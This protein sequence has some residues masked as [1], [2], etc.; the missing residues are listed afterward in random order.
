MSMSH[1]G[2]PG[3]VI[4]FQNKL[5]RIATCVL[6]GGI[7]LSLSGMASAQVALDLSDA[8]LAPGASGSIAAS[9][10]TDGSAVA[11]Q[12]DVLYDPT[13]VSLGT[14]NA[15]PAL[16][17]NHSIASNPISSGRDRIVITTSPVTALGSGVM[18]TINLTALGSAPA[19]SS[20]L[21]FAGVVISDDTA[22]PITP[23]ALTPGVLTITGGVGPVSPNSNP[24]E[25]IPAIPVWG[26]LLLAGLISL[27]GGRARALRLASV[28]ALALLALGSPAQVLAQNLPG[29]A[30]GDGR[31]DIEDVRLIVER[32]LER[33]VL[34]GDG[35]CN[36]DNA[37][38]VLDT[39]CSQLPFVPGETAPIILGPGDRSIPADIAFEMNLFAADPDERSTQAWSLVNG[40]AG[41]TVSGDGVLTWTPP[42]SAA[43]PNA[44]RIRV[45]DD[46]ARSDEADFSINVFVLP[47]APAAN[48]APVLTVPGN[49]SL[50][51]G[52]PIAAQASATDADAGDTLSFSLINGPAGMTINSSDGTLSWTPQANQPGLAD[53]VIQVEDAAGATDFGSFTVE[54][55]PLNAG[56]TAVDDVYIARKG[57]TLIIPA[58]EGVVQNDEDPNDDSL[59]ATRLSDPALGTVDSFSADG[60]FSYTPDGPPGITIGMQEECQITDSP[61]AQAGAGTLAAGDVDNDG[62][63][64]LAALRRKDTTET[65]VVIIDPVDCTVELAPVLGMGIPDFHGLTTLV[66][67]DD[68]PE[69]ELVKAYSAFQ[70]DIVADE[71]GNGSDQR[72]MAVNIDGSPLDAWVTNH[73][74]GGLSAEPSRFEDLFPFDA[75]ANS[76]VAADLD[77]D[78]SVELLLGYNSATDFSDGLPSKLALVAWDGRSG[79]V[80]WEFVGAQVRGSNRGTWPV[81]VDL[82]LDGDTEIIFNHHVLDHEGNLLFDLP[83]APVQGATFDTL[84]SAVAN[85]DNDAFP[86]IIAY[87]EEAITLFSHDGQIQWQRERLNTDFGQFP[88]SG[89]TIAELDG[90]PLPEFATMLDIDPG[91]GVTLFAFDDNGDELWNQAERGFAAGVF[92]ETSTAVAFD[93]DGDGIDELVQQRGNNTVPFFPDGRPVD[94]PPEE[95]IYIFDGPTGD[96]IDFLPYVATTNTQHPLTVAD[97]DED[98]S[99]EIVI[100]PLVSLG[101]WVMQIIG[102]ISDNPWPGT[103]STRFQTAMQPTYRSADGAVPSTIEPHWLQP[104][105]NAWNRV[106]PDRDP[107]EP[108]TDSFTYRVSDGAFD[109]NT[110]TVNIELRPAGTPPFFLSEPLAGIS[111]GIAY[112]YTPLIVDVDPGDEVTLSL[113]SAPAGMT[114]DPATGTLSWYPE[115]A[116]E[117]PVSILA[118]DTL[119][120]SSAQIFTVSVGDPVIVPDVVGSTEGA[121]ESTLVSANLSKGSVFVASSTT[122]PAGQVLSQTPLAGSAADFGSAVALTLS[123]GPAP[124]DRDDDGDGFSE[125]QGDCDDNNNTIFPGAPDASN[126]GIDQDCD[127]LDGNKTLVAIEISPGSKRVLTG[128]PTPLIAT[129]IFDDGTAQN[130]TAIATWTNGPTFSAGSAGAFQASATFRGVTGTA[131]FTVLDRVAEDLAP[132]ARIDSPA[133]GATVT[134][135]TDIEGLVSDANLLRWELAYRYAGEDDFVVF[136]EGG[137]PA[138][139]GPPIGEFDPTTLLNGLYDIRLRA[140]DRGGN[141]SEDSTTVQVEGQMKIGNFT[142]RYVDLELPLNG[143]PITLARTYD[144]R[145][146]RVGDFG[147]GWRLAVNSIEVR[148]NRELGSAWRVFRQGLTFGLVEEDL[149]L[150]AIRLPDGRIE[151][152]EMVVVPNASPIIPFPPLTQS[153]RFRPLPGTLGT[154]EALGENNVSILDAQPG[155]VTL[156]L[157]SDGSIYNPTLFRYTTRTGQ[158]WISIH[159]RV[160][161]GPSCPAARYSPSRQPQ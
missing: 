69:L 67:L 20:N 9:I 83:H 84:T 71:G 94:P 110:A 125:N 120:L 136:D 92:S 12:F 140:Y 11:L 37:I 109:S 62:R 89:I 25:R 117:Y 63:V 91:A 149:H 95:G 152:F 41:L 135:P 47:A 38:N 44:V 114:L 155:P 116:G 53:V 54:A 108:E 15:G 87:D 130:L 101:S 76:P 98:G 58:P 137:S 154:L 60:S 142:L 64:E 111:R 132:I 16:T 97:V 30:N 24:P 33:G 107:F 74:V 159:R 10:A 18:A 77:G 28:A 100:T 147:V 129:G 118:T 112:E 146:K 17:A 42:A 105:R 85:F 81:L 7:G 158:R 6:I 138:G 36:R 93:I 156:R 31:I 2:N 66:N 133:G 13:V 123:L 57:E 75:S 61:A 157:D 99:A 150:A 122:V 79:N 139:G 72:L 29:D 4:A 124:L 45:V 145:D 80:R 151:A 113:A 131:D 23:S 40:P 88:Y 34:P 46:T 32:I 119:G 51:V 35:D 52:T 50:R 68:D 127:G 106:V 141:V 103:R 161:S 1:L 55:T 14:V 21:S 22:N 86:E 43:G 153:V 102:G 19:G 27:V 90:D 49:Q 115:A 56:P 128:E 96:V 144:S 73:N 5:A 39:V 70:P 3:C 59:N 48:A 82:D 160:S 143:I 65:D 134:A 148:T 8:S 104:G 78:G 121:A 26:L 126:D